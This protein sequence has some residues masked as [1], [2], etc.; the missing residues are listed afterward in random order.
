MVD[1]S[2]DQQGR[3]SPPPDT[4]HLS[5]EGAPG[6]H[7]EGHSADGVVVGSTGSVGADVVGVSGEGTGVVDSDG[8]SVAS[9]VVSSVGSSVGDAWSEG[10]LDGSTDG[11]A[12]SSDGAS[13]SA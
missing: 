1:P 5:A 8:D 12:S 13:S 2:F 11:G 4:H 6:H 9:S 10:S 3:P 7:S